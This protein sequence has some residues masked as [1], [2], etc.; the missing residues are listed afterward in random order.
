M[1]TK[2]RVS[3]T[4]LWDYRWNYHYRFHW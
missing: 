1:L 2:H 3:S 4:S